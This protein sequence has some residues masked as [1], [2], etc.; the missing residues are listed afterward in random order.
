MSALL[1]FCRKELSQTMRDPMFMRILIVGPILYVLLFG[2]VATTDVKNIRAIFVDHDVT[3]ASRTLEGAF[4]RSGYFTAEEFGQ[5]DADVRDALDSGR[6]QVAIVIPPGYERTIASGGSAQVQVMV[7]GTDSN[8]GIVAQ[9]YASSIIAAAASEISNTSRRTL[10]LQGLPIASVDAR[11]RVWFNPTLSALNYMVP[12]LVALVLTAFTTLLTAQSVVKE[13]IS[14]TLE[15]LMVTPIKRWQFILGKILPFVGIGLIDVLVTTAVGV[16]WFRVPLTGSFAL[17]VALSLLGV[18]ALIGQGLLISTVSK[19]QQQAT[20]TT[21]LVLLPALLMSG[22][23]FPVEGMPQW[24]QPI[25]YLF[26]LRYLLII[27]RGIFL[28]G[29]T[30]TELLPQAAGLFVLGLVTFVLAVMRFSK[31]LEV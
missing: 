8:V 30:F 20:V 31:Q 18:F 28:K 6:A 17:L 10:A 14:G 26:P 25:T 9:G 15:Q 11:A 27:T 3:A 5:T 21:Q 7:D 4:T 12:G 24:L 19:T 13:R 1:A 22:F 2:Y 29:M 16:W 23:M